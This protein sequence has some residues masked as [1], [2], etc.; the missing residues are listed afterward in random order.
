MLSRRIAER[1]YCEAVSFLN[2]LLCLVIYRK[3][4]IP[5]LASPTKVT[6][7]QT[8]KSVISN[9]TLT[10]STIIRDP[11][12]ATSGNDLRAEVDG[13]QDEEESEAEGAQ[14]R[15]I[16]P[17]PKTLGQKASDANPQTHMASTAGGGDKSDG[18]KRKRV[19]PETD[20]GEGQLEKSK[21]VISASSEGRDM[22]VSIPGKKRKK[23]D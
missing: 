10:T 8:F 18:K 1:Q 12:S 23:K 19:D 14:E 21:D 15:I 16:P 13:Q 4:F 6:N 2:P 20:S 3:D 7:R 5:T 17:N 11:G 9:P 22:R